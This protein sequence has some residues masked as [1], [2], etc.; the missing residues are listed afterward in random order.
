MQPAAEPSE[1]E[2][3]SP[4]AILRPALVL[5]LLAQLAYGAYAQGMALVAAD[6]SAVTWLAVYEVGYLAV[7]GLVLWFVRRDPEARRVFAPPRPRMVEACL[8]VGIVGA[9]VLSA[10]ERGIPNPWGATSPVELEFASGL[11]WWLSLLLT[12]LLPAL[13]EEW[14]YRGLLLTR[15]ARVLP[16]WFALAVQAMLFALMHCDQVMLLPHFVFGVLA[17]VLRLLAGA[18]WPCMLMHFLWNGYIVLQ[19][20]G[21]V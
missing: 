11:P 6:A 17:G 2:P 4:A 10:W 20:Y 8:V 12:A 5:W 18:L 7:C 13:F 1:P 19:V 16:Q 15:L 3:P 9:L 21:L 14:M